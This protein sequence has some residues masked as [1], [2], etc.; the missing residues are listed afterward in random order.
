V[1]RQLTCAD[2]KWR[3]HL[4]SRLHIITDYVVYI[5]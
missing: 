3:K 5:G 1:G 4:L 2:K